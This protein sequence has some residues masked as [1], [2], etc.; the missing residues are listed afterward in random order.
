MVE[1]LKELERKIADLRLRVEMHRK[2]PHSS[3]LDLFRASFWDLQKTGY[4]NLCHYVPNIPEKFL[5]HVLYNITL[6]LN[7]NYIIFK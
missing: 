4:C 7:E 5:Q 1:I 6:H 2:K 3:N